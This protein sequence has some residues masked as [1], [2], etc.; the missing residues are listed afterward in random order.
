MSTTE[1][2][3]SITAWLIPDPFSPIAWDDAGEVNSIIRAVIEDAYLRLNLKLNI[4]SP[5]IL[6]IKGQS[7]G[8]NYISNYNA[9]DSHSQ[10][11]HFWY[12]RNWDFLRS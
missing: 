8:K 5:H 11:K 1:W 12:G 9:V 4:R 7:K 3:K 10:Y 6:A 2:L